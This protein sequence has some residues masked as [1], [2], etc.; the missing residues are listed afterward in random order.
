M[1]SYEQAHRLLSIVSRLLAERGQLDFAARLLEHVDEERVQEI[2]GE[3]A[4][5]IANR[6]AGEFLDEIADQLV[7]CAA[8][9]G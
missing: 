1:N 5:A 6:H 3:A 4:F 9:A 8:Q 7:S 2:I